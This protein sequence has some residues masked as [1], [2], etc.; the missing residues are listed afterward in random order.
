MMPKVGLIVAIVAAS[1]ALFSAT[2]AHHNNWLPYKYI[3]W[4]AALSLTTLVVYGIDKAAARRSWR[5]VPELYLH[6][7]SLVGGWPGALVAQ[8]LFR[9]KT[10]KQPFQT[11]FWLTVLANLGLVWWFFLRS[12]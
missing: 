4:A 1:V 6:L 5:R 3:W 2:W 11:L 8:Q 7:L 12:A 9:H 10:R